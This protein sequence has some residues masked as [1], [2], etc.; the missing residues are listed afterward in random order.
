M[1]I[2]FDEESKTRGAQRNAEVER[3]GREAIAE[4]QLAWVAFGAEPKDVVM[5]RRR[6]HAL[7]ACYQIATEIK[8]PSLLGKKQSRDA[9]GGLQDRCEVETGPLKADPCTVLGSLGF[10]V[11][12][13]P[14]SH[15][16]LCHQRSAIN[17]SRVALRS[18]TVMAR[19][20]KA[21]IPQ[22]AEGCPT[23]EPSQSLPPP[24][25]PSERSPVGLDGDRPGRGLP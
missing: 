22:G 23:S 15:R 20:S 9:P 13:H 19:D 2:Y 6:P 11:N 5:C 3:K 1:G 14:R 21:R 7:T 17:I 25:E 18:A 10:V 16:K 8:G 4:A 12:S 24:Q